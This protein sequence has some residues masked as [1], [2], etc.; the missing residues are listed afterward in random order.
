VHVRPYAQRALLDGVEIAHDE[1]VVRLSITPGKPHQLRI[2][3]ECCAPFVREITAKQAADAGELR[4]PLVPR[5]ARLRVD[6][7]PATRVYVEGV[8][9]GTAGESQRSP[10]LVR[11]PAGGYVGTARVRLE[12]PGAPVTD[13]Q[14]E[15]RAGEPHT[16]PGPLAPVAAPAAPGP[17]PRAPAGEPDATAEAPDEDA[18][19]RSQAPDE[20][21]P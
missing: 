18:A 9:V 12:L 21:A 5:P 19:L 3:H 8:P 16:V 10:I 11:V 20:A 15:L 7:D 14:L 13:M 6:G 1:T 4:V 2:E 17:R